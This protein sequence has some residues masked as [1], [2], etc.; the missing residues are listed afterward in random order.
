VGARAIRVILIED[1]EDDALLV[2]R[3]LCAHD[4][5]VSCTRVEDRPAL[6]AA[7]ARDV[8]DVVISDHSLPRF[9]APAALAVV[10]ADHPDLPFIVVSG[11]VSEEMAVRVMRAGAQDYISKSA[12][13]RLGPALDREL[14]EAANRLAHRAS[15][16]RLRS[17][18][19]GMQDVVFSVD[20]E[21]RYTGIYGQR[22]DWVND[23]GSFLGKTAR[24]CM[25][26]AQAELHEAAYVRALRGESV[27]FEW[28]TPTRAGQR[29]FQTSLSPTLSAG[30]DGVAREIVGVTRDVSQQKN[31]QEQLL[32]SDRLATVGAV[33]IGLAHEINNP[34]GALL[35]NLE[36]MVEASEQPVDE[37]L[38]DAWEA[39]TRVRDIVRDVKLFSRAADERHGT[40]DVC[41]L[42][43]TTLRLASAELK[44][45]AVVIKRYEGTV[46]LVQGNESRLGQVFLN[47][48]VN[49]SQAFTEGATEATI[50][51]DVLADDETVTVTISD[52]GSGMPSD[53]VTRLFTPFFTTKAAGGGTGIGLSISKR[54]IDAM[55]GEIDVRSEVG[56]GSTFR[57]KL[58]RATSAARSL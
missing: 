30:A 58:P 49:A 57:V 36:R 56:K 44:H 55:G 4:F 46:Q 11:T 33:T 5:E 12:L 22:S 43:D 54:I 21:L 16:E 37:A 35:L 24:A 19:A 53:V 42:L 28:S 41:A 8:P 45:R 15:D 18:L 3:A 23:E 27:V 7:L 1:V 25:P 52:S 17:L 50:T 13:A 29:Y 40:V 20:A 38:A 47:L 34:L 32:L 39:A 31:L 48:L 6:E 9:D 26:P 2:L 51:L 10:R 14:R